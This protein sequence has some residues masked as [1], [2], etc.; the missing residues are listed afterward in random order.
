MLGGYEAVQIDE[1]MNS[2][3]IIKKLEAAGWYLVRVKGSHHQFKHTERSGLVTVKHP[4][5]DIPKATLYSIERQ[6][7]WR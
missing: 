2:K 5:G 6:A 3:Q 7:G 1:F 4:D